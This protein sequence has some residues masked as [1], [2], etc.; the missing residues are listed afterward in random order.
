MSSAG[1][2]SGRVQVRK[3]RAE[4]EGK[5]SEDFWGRVYEYTLLQSFTVYDCSTVYRPKPYSMIF[6]VLRP[7]NLSL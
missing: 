4:F 3:P 7:P 1:R 6:Y 5:L 2:G